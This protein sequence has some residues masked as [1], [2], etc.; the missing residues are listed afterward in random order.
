MRAHHVLR[1]IGEL[2]ITIGLILLLFV[3]YELWVTDLF[4][5]RT[6]AKL[7]GVL[8]REWEQHPSGPVIDNVDIGQGIAVLRIPR[9]GKS[10]DPVIVEGVGTAALQ[11]GP[12]HF[13][14]S[15]LP[16]AIGNF[17]VSGHRTTYGKPF[18]R[19][20]EMKTGDKVVIETRTRWVTYVVTG[21]EIVSPSDVGV[22]LPVPRQPSAKPTARLFTFTTCNPKFSASQ[23]LVITGKMLS[24]TAKSA[25]LPPALLPASA[26]RS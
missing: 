1:S 15:A 13:P 3:A 22:I 18:E 26:G 16:G 9:F 24:D 10:Y 4:N 17:V 14:T 20:N 12:G 23:R 2:L 8:E 19:L 7:H 11:K 5:H 25:G 6:Q 21:K